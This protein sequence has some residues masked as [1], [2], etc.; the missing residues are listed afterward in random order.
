[1]SRGGDTQRRI[2]GG[3]GVG[4]DFN[5][6][7][8]FDAAGDDASY[9][10]LKFIGGSPLVA[11][12]GEPGGPFSYLNLDTG[13]GSQVIKNDGGGMIGLSNTGDGA[14]YGGEAMFGGEGKMNSDGDT[15]FGIFISNDGL[16][17]QYFRSTAGKTEIY[18]AGDGIT[19]VSPG[20]DIND[21]AIKNLVEGASF[22]VANSQDVTRDPTTHA[23]TAIT[24][25]E[26]MLEM[27]TDLAG[28]A[29]F[30]YNLPATNPGGS[31][32]V[33]NDGGTLKIT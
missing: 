14:A 19:I 31:E 9:L 18:N 4:I 20:A 21:M 5:K 22:Y 16:G 17:G 27:F 3:D 1:M 6:T 25:N 12:G 7:N 26:P 30:L 33:W 13:T 23:I 8:Q 32:R 15:I 11:P 28:N 29:C 2:A 24:Y 10:F